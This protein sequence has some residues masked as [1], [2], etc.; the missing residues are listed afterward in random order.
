ME[1]NWHPSC[2]FKYSTSN[3]GIEISSQLCG[4]K[5]PL[6]H[7]RGKLDVIEEEGRK[8]QNS[9]LIP[10]G[11]GW[12]DS[13]NTQNAENRRKLTD[14]DDNDEEIVPKVNGKGRTSARILKNTQEKPGT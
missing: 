10:N 11:I 9:S 13:D 2:E 7:D 6:E 1:G 14:E 8:N 5:T 12:K 3:E 4:T